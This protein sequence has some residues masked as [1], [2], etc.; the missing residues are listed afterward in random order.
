MTPVD[1]AIIAIIVVSALLGAFRGLM[2]E[3][4]ALVSLMVAL[5]VAW[6]YSDLVT[7]YLASIS[8][9]TA[10]TWVARGLLFFAVVMGG[11]LLGAIL[12]YFVR[13]SIFSGFDRMMG[14]LFGTLRGV[15]ILGLLVMLARLVQIDQ[16]PWWLKSTLI[17]YAS[18]VGD[19]V[20]SIVGER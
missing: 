2:R 8:S 17:P 13:M 10:R 7:P 1:Y 6:Q 3:V 4:I 11:A 14:L 19:L 16:Q 20:T 18:L 15:L 9:G 5:W 12:N